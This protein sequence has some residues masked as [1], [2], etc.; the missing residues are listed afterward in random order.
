MFKFKNDYSKNEV[1]ENME[2]LNKLKD[3]SALKIYLASTD[4][5]LRWSHGEVTKPETINYRTFR[6]E[7]DGRQNQNEKPLWKANHRSSLKVRVC[8]QV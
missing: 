1:K 3:F 8:R 4:E 5:V 2:D 7:K 6:A